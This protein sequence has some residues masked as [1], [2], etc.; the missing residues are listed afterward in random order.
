MIRTARIRWGWVTVAAVALWLAVICLS[1]QEER[2]SAPASRGAAGPARLRDDA[3]EAVRRQNTAAFQSLFR[4]ESVGPR[5][6]SDYFARLF[7]EPVTGLRLT[8]ITRQ[9]LRYLVLRGG[10]GPRAVCSAW[11]IQDDGD[12]SVLS[13]APPLTDV[14]RAGAPAGQAAKPMFMT[15]SWAP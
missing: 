4:A 8:V 6:A 7:A 11:Q 9:D 3:Q 1:L 13:G 10:E 2:A 5:Y 14:C 12:R 15:Y